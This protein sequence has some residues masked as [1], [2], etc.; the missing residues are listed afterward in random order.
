MIKQSELIDV[1]SS[2]HEDIQRP[3]TYQR[4]LLKDL[5]LTDG[6]ALII[7]GIR[8]CGKSTLL[9]QLILKLT[10]RSL[11]I[12]FDTPKLYNFDFTDFR[13]LDEIIGQDTNLKYLFFDEI[14]IIEGWELYVR[15]K[16]DAG[17]LVVVT[18]S[19]ASLL[20]RELGTKLTGRH[21]TKELFPFSFSEF[22][23]Y[24]KLDKNNNSLE[25]YL[26]IGGFP[27]FI[28]TGNEDV[29]KAL[30]N[31]ILYRDIAVRHNIRDEK[32]LK[33]LLMFMVANVGNL[34]SANKLKTII[35]VK[36]SVTVL[37][38]LSFL[39]DTYLIHLVP[40]FT[41]SYRAQ[42]VNPKK[43]YF[44]DNGL[45]SAISPSFT[46]DR[47][48]KF[49][50]LLFTTLRLYTSEIYYYN[51]NAKECDFVVCKNTQVKAL[52]QVCFELNFDNIE[53][54]QS[55]VFDA[56]NF[57][58]MKIGYIVTKNQKDKI[59]IKGKTIIVIPFYETEFETLLK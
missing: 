58:N 2:Q 13:I 27:Q 59:S 32:P 26:N 8:R 31:D 33:N 49:E 54:E 38:Y 51:E 5:H 7:S 10:Q 39:E 56:M 20:S 1:I 41:Y 57:F 35:G 53:R 42:L 34:I 17:F 24:K 36:S 22:C 29:L 46:D 23:G 15:E 6:F 48:R 4:D 16:L 52:I 40:K 14:Q 47:G 50:N 30:I 3:V 28:D 25:Q 11:Y 37:E 44:I 18:G 9:T 43:I 19:N 55:G 21:I 12:N 45:Q